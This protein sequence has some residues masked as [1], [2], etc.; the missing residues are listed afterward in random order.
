M[1]KRHLQQQDGQSAVIIALALIALVGIVGLVVD[2]GRGYGARRQSQNASDAAAFAGASQLAVRTG[3][4]PSDDAKVRDAIR[5]YSM[6]NGVAAT[7]DITAY[8]TRVGI[9]GVSNQVGSGTIPSDANGVRVETTIR[10]VPFLIGVITGGNQ[11]EAKTYAIAK[12][13][14]LLGTG[15]LRPVTLPD[16]NF[17]YGQQYKIMGDSTGSGN[18][19]YLNLGNSSGWGFNSNGPV[20]TCPHSTGNANYLATWLSPYT[21]V[22]TP[23]LT[24]DNLYICGNSGI[25]N[26]N[27]L[28]QS[29]A[30]WWTL[31]PDGPR[32]W[33][34]P[35]YDSTS[36]NGSNLQ[37]HITKIAIFD[38][39][40]YEQGNG[41]NS[42]NGVSCNPVAPANKCIAGTFVRYASLGEIDEGENCYTSEV[43]ACGVKMTE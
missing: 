17:V 39:A 38:L 36:G 9:S 41:Q 40:G 43:V 33:F 8:Y 30:D 24:L 35:I 27:E 15:G 29:M 4:G 28:R 1:I 3:S 16:Q 22:T 20:G 26:S 2:A 21:A 10:L 42:S 37:Y 13:G 23:G 12:I 7:S 31:Y 32:Y 34:V 19:Q 14:Q 25:S 11:Y 6:N 5:A 18:F